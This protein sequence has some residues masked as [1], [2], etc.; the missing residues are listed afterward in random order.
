MD[1]KTLITGWEV[2]KYGPV[3]PEYPVEYICDHIKRREQTLFRSCY[4]GT[5]VYQALLADMHDYSSVNNYDAETTYQQG[6]NVQYDGCVFVS[7]CDNNTDAPDDGN[8][9]W[10]VA[11]KFEN[12]AN[13]LLW[14]TNLRYWLAYEICFTSIDYTTYHLAAHGA[15]KQ[16]QESTGQETVSSAELKG[17]KRKMRHDAD[18]HLENMLAW[19]VETTQDDSNDYTYSNVSAVSDACTVNECIPFKKRRRRRFYFKN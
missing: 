4:L 7:T 17:L 13:N 15:T 16:K 2:V 18:E 1:V 6:Q 8:A 10:E 14:C 9:C 19:M 12:E 5:S 11:P 3:H